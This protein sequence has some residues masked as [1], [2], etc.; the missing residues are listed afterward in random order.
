MPITS[1]VDIWD[2]VCEECK[3][4]ITVV[5]FDC[6]IAPLKPVAFN[7]GELVIAC[8]E[9]YEMDIIVENYSEIL[10]R[11]ASAAMGF[12][13]KI[14]IVVEGEEEK[15][16]MAEQYSEGLSF[17]DFFTFKNFVVGAKTDLPMPHLLPLPTAPL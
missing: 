10:K 12:D 6:F 1:V 17:E 4:I 2:L 14:K 11:S 8:K 5:A 16:L 15:I 7:A 9:E 3:K 13:V